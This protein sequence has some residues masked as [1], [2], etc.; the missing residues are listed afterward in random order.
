MPE[1]GQSNGCRSDG[2]GHGS[3]DANAVHSEYAGAVDR[4][5]SNGVIGK[6]AGA[7]QQLE[8]DVFMGGRNSDIVRGAGDGSGAVNVTHALLG[9]ISYAGTNQ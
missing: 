2:S 5:S 4:W 8:A 1:F 7:E 6:Y 9:K 3:L